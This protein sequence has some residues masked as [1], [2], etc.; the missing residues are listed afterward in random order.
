MW[1]SVAALAATCLLTLTPALAAESATTGVKPIYAQH[2]KDARAGEGDEAQSALALSVFSAEL[3]PLWEEFIALEPEARTA[4]IAYD[5]FFYT[6]ADQE[7]DVIEK[8]LAIRTESESTDGKA[9]VEVKMQR[10]TG[11]DGA[12]LMFSM[13]LEDGAWKVDDIDYGDH[14]L[15]GDIAEAKAAAQ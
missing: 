5:I 13:R 4:G 14:T 6:Q 3:K 1:R 2:L 9:G 12:T 15:R 11:D 8:T 10:W 7:L